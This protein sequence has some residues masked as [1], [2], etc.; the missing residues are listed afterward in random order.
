MKHFN[1][2][3]MEKVDPSKPNLELYIKHISE[4]NRNVLQNTLINKGYTVEYLNDFEHMI[5]S[6]EN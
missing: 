3:D 2:D 5:I 4:D 6:N 1:N